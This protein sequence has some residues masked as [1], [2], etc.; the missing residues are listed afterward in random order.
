MSVQE[1]E[2]LQAKTRLKYRL[3]PPLGIVMMLLLFIS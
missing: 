3:F 1:N 2:W